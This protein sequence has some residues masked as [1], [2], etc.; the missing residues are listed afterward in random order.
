MK[1]RKG[2]TMEINIRCP[3]C[4]GKLILDD[5]YNDSYIFNDTYTDISTCYCEQCESEYIINTHYKFSH[6]ELGKKF[7]RTENEQAFVFGARS[8]L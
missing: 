2:L 4:K 5:E 3:K 8:N 6:F 7:P 1:N